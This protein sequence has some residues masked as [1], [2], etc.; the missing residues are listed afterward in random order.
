[1][2]AVATRRPAPATATL[3]QVRALA[4][5]L[6]YRVFENLMGEPRTA[7]QM[8]EHL[9]THPTRLYH[10][11]RVL[12]RAGLIRPSGTKQKR[13]TTEKY[14]K[15]AVERIDAGPRSAGMPSAVVSVLLEGVLG[16]TLVDMQR[17]S[18]PLGGKRPARAVPYLKRYRIRAT[19]EQAAEI[20]ARLDALAD[21]CERASE[22]EGS[23][24]FG[25]TL[26][27]YETLDATTRRRRR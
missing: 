5:P 9:G 23:T 18:K 3:A 6:R 15:A 8:A 16:T 14:F 27:F 21:L 20:R 10:H 1:M 4:D 17:A 13:G 24:E 11:F 7:K 2:K 19:R 12:E 25:L 22:P 26:A